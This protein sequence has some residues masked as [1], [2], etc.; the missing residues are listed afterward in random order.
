MKL[1]TTLLPLLPSISLAQ[2]SG[3]IITEHR[4]SCPIP[5]HEGDD[6]PFSYDPAKG[7]LCLNLDKEDYYTESYHASLIGYAEI[8]GAKEPVKF[9]GCSDADCEDCEFVDVV[10]RMDRPGTIEAPCFEL[11]GKGYLFVGGP[12]RKEEL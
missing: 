1:T 9:G 11:R 2:Y 3:T 5:H 12:G 7:S 10:R 4:G 6:T 8:P